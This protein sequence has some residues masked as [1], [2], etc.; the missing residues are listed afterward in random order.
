MDWELYNSFGEVTGT[1]EASRDITD[2]LIVENSLRRNQEKMRFLALH[3]SLTGLPNRLLFKDRLQRAII[4]SR[5]NV[6]K[7]ALLFLDLDRFKHINDSLGHDYGDNF[8]KEI[9]ARLKKVVRE[10]DSVAR[11]GGG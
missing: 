6:Q 8:L 5:R 10:A 7:L 11:L 3:D 9:A 4:E 2:R 1:I